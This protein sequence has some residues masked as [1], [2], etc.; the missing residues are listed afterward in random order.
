MKRWKILIVLAVLVPAGISTKLYGGPLA[1]WANRYGGDIVS[2]MF[3]FF[4][5][6]LLLPRIDPYRFAAGV[7]VFCVAVEFSQFLSCPA[8]AAMR[9]NIAGRTILGSEFDWLDFPFYIVGL[10]MALT[11]HRLLKE[12]S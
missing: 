3:I 9:G 10:F 1:V 6:I 7:F 8:L 2:P 11:L 12:K 5:V 4:L